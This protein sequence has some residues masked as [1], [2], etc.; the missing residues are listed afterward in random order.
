MRSSQ[1]GTHQASSPAG[2]WPPDQRH[3]DHEGVQ[4]HP[5]GQAE[6]DRRTIVR[7]EN[8]KPAKTDHDDRRRCDHACPVAEAD[9]DGGTGAAA[10]T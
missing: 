9:P 3:A 7:C 10:W 8:T 5:E 4:E 6:A 1:P 2:T